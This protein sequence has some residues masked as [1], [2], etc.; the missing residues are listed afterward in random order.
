MDR[1]HEMEV[2]VAVVEAGS[3]AEAGRRLRLSAPAVTRTIAGLEARLGTRL[4]NRTT[5]SLS[6]TEAGTRFL[7]SC[8]RLLAEV[9]AAEHEASGET[10]T[11]HG[12]LSVTASL[13]FGR[14]AVAPMMGGFLGAYPRVTVSLML[15]DRVVNLVEDNF[16]VAIRIGQL[17]DSSLVARRLGE[18]RRVL[19][20]SPGYIAARGAP[21]HPTDLKSHSIIGFTGS[22][23]N[24]S[25]HYFEG[26]RMKEVGLTPRLEVNDA[27]TAMAAAAAGYGITKLF[28]YMTG[29]LLASGEL[30]P[31]L[32]PY[33]PA[34]SPVQ[35]VYP[36]SRLMAGKVRA[37]VDWTAPRLSSELV[38]LSMRAVHQAA[39]DSQSRKT[40][41]ATRT[42]SR[43]RQ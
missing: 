34:S 37:F 13:T 21:Q 9:E 25:F 12:H 32:E 19:V 23:P 7:A 42:P 16:D 31:V 35:I 18:V 20:A 29:R 41:P 6:V 26:G 24:R 28:S 2:F 30:V 33:W 43:R 22:M 5:R 27:E 4:L 17:P 39:D 36:H 3:L 38:E 8:Q 14:I 10:A 15:Y 1:L 11:P 40:G